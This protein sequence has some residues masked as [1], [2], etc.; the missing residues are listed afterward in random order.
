[1]KAAGR[2]EAAQRKK[3]AERK[4]ISVSWAASGQG[5]GG[6]IREGEADREW[7]PDRVL[8]I[9]SGRSTVGLEVRPDLEVWLRVPRKYPEK[10]AREF[11]YGHREWVEQHRQRLSEGISRRDEMDPEEEKRLWQLAAQVIPERVRVYASVMGVSYGT[12]RIKAQK[13]RYGSCSSKGNLN[14]NWKL[15]CMPPEI[16]DYVVVHELA[17]RRQMNHSLRFWKE[18]EHVLPDYQERRRWLKENGG[19]F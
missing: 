14:F 5:E 7:L 3:A 19:R 9:R 10:A 6:Q 1:M 11:L 12:I 2:N 15:I 4:W 16:L 18:V 13:T 17:H 8:L